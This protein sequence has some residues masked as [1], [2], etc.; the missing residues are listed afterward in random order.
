MSKV[1]AEIDALKCITTLTDHM[2]EDG[3]PIG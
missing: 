3:I 1:V 2:N